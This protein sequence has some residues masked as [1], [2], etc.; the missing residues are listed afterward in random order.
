MIMKSYVLS[1]PMILMSRI[2]IK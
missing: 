2:T 1:I